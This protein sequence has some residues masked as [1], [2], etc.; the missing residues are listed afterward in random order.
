MAGQRRIIRDP[1]STLLRAGFRPA[2]DDKLENER[3]TAAS[4]RIDALA[5]CGAQLLD[6]NAAELK[7]TDKSLFD[8]I[9]RAGGAGGDANDDGPLS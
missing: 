5:R 8:E 7:E 2:Q 6:A 3:S 1:H 9:V 4:E